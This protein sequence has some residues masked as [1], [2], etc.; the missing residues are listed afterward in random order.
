[1]TP[2]AATRG[3]RDPPYQQQR[4]STWRG[5]LR[6]ETAPSQVRVKVLRR[7]L[8]AASPCGGLRF[9]HTF[10]A[11]VLTIAVGGHIINRDVRIHLWS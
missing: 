2:L 6:Q 1:M 11:P 3:A 8:R 4:Y 10:M 9:P 5:N 7:R